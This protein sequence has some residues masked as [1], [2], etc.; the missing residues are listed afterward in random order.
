MTDMFQGQPLVPGILEVVNDRPP[1][2][3]RQLPQMMVDVP[4][5]QMEPQQ[6]PARMASALHS[7]GRNMVHLFTTVN[8]KE[9]YIVE[10]LSGAQNASHDLVT[11]L[12]TDIAM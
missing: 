5:W 7:F 10:E 2:P 4:E 3:R 1:S 9:R 8:I 12:V 11:E 6:H